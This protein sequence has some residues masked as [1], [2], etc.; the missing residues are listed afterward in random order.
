MADRPFASTEDAVRH[1]PGEWTDMRLYDTAWH[2]GTPTLL[3][4]TA[5]GR[6]ARCQLTTD[7]AVRVT[8]SLV[9]YLGHLHRSGQ[10]A[11]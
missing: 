6:R 11:S 2:D 3:L 5:D 7:Q 4:T 8:K 10:E 1:L 9:G